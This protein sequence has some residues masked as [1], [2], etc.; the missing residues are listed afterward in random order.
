MAVDH[1]QPCHVSASW[2]R[3]LVDSEAA[4]IGEVGAQVGKTLED[5]AVF[6]VSWNWYLS[7][8][9]RVRDI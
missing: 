9:R 7:F 4:G 1:I 2:N 8:E 3:I 6:R 5:V